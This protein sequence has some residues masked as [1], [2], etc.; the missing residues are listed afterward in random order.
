M[1]VPFKNEP[2]IDFSVQ[3]NV[4]RFQKTLE[5]VKHS[6]GKTLPIVIDGEHIIKDDPFDSINPAN[7]SELV[8]KVSKATKD[9]VDNAFESSNKA[10][11]AWRKWSHKD[12]A[13]LMLRVAA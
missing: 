13:E 11:D 6:L 3:E 12:R 9:D 7:T 8:A 2:G 10:Y 4:E 5:K 1:V